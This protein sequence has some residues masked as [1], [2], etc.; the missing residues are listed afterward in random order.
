MNNKENS[1]TKKIGEN[2]NNLME[3]HSLS[4]RGLSK[5][6]GIAQP[7]LSRLSKGEH[8]SPGLGVLQKI[9]NFFKISIAQLIGDQE[10]NLSDLPGLSKEEPDKLIQA[11]SG[12]ETTILNEN[13][14]FET[15][16]EE[17]EPPR[18]RF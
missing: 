11:A 13:D 8:A 4:F 16:E 15:E 12:A 10:I 2:L 7:H 9:S 14:T 1:K 5:A 18:P 17:K 6:T 3:H